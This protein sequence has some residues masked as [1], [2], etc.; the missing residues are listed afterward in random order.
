MKILGYLFTFMAGAWASAAGF[1]Y[2]LINFGV[3]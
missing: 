3:I 2:A 1:V